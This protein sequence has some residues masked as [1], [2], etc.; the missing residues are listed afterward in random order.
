[1]RVD[2][3][4]NLGVLDG[5]G[6]KKKEVWLC[7]RPQLKASLEKDYHKAMIQSEVERGRLITPRF[8]AQ[9]YL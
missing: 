6:G 7:T 9:V 1:L 2:F 5:E 8:P 4:N 3:E